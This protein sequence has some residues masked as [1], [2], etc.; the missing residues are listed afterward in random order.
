MRSRRGNGLQEEEAIMKRPDRPQ[1][2]GA[3]APYAEGFRKELSRQG[4]SPWTA[5]EHMYLMSGLSRW[6][7][8]RDLS[9]AQLSSAR[10]EEFLI[11]RRARRQARWITPRAIAPLLGYLRGLGIVPAPAAPAPGSP[12]EVL[13]VEFAGYLAT[14]RGLG[15]ATIA[16]YRH[17]AGLFPGACAPEP[18]V[19]GCGLE[20]LGLQQINTF[21]LAECAQR[22]I[23]S[24]KNVVTALRVL[25]RFLYLEGYTSVLLADAVPRAIPWRDSGRS[26]ALEPGQV[27]RL[28]TGAD[29]GTPACRPHFPLLTIL[30]RLG[31]RASEVAALQLADVDWRA[32]EIALRRKRGRKDRLPLPADVGEAIA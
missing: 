3:L 10:I 2:T 7:D 25:M 18:A 22:S 9:P 6:L 30:A 1:V 32:G 26:R 8:G 15:S 19:E 20:R 31:L 13:L 4:Y 23:G 12:A 27:S 11:H 14:E 17:L 21:L 28:L 5:P 24:T 29:R 16:S